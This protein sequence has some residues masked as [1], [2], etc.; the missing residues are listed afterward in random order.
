MSLGQKN[1]VKMKCS[2]CGRIN[3][4]THKNKK[5]ISK[6]LKLKKYCP[7]C[8]THTEHKEAKK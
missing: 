6:K 3:Y 2:K 7:S 5:A 1:L 8:R 4:W